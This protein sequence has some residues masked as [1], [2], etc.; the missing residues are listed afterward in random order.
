MAPVKIHITESLGFLKHKTCR[1]A[2]IIFGWLEKNSILTPYS[3]MY[4]M[5]IRTKTS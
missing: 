5:D 3:H 4:N 2:W 1:R